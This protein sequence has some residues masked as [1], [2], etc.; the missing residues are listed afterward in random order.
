M[1]FVECK[2]DWTLVK[3]LIEEFP[4]NIIHSGNKSGVCKRL[5]KS[6]NCVGLV[7]EDPRSIQPSFLE[8]LDLEYELDELQI[9]VKNDNETKN[10]LIIL[11][12]KIE[13]WIIETAVL[14]E[15]ATEPTSPFYPTTLWITTG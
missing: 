8:H 2:P 12:P 14:A 5:G 9:Q 13:E 7:D 3:V 15:T 11:K 4:T 10:R 1:I 6:N